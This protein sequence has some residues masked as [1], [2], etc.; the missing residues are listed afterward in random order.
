MACTATLPGGA[1]D[2]ALT[3][4]DVVAGCGNDRATYEN[5][6]AVVGLAV[7]SETQVSDSDLSHYCNEDGPVI[8]P[9]PGVCVPHDRETT[10]THNQTKVFNV[11]NFFSLDSGPPAAGVFTPRVS[12]LA[13]AIM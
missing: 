4:S 7:P 1:R 9:P 6:G 12:S 11:K 8:P 10:L 3:D 13:Q 2:L 5:T